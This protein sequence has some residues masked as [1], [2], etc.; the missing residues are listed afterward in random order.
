MLKHEDN[1]QSPSPSAAKVRVTPEELAAAVTALQIRKEGSP[2]TIAIGDA[3]DELGLD[4]SP[5]EVLAELERLHKRTREQTQTALRK[6][7]ATVLASFL[8]LCLSG[9]GLY[10][11]T[12]GEALDSSRIAPGTAPF[13]LEPDILALNTASAT[14][15]VT[16]LTEAPFGR[17]LYCSP[18]AIERAAVSREYQT[19]PQRPLNQSLP[20]MTWPVVKYGKD[21]YVRGWI[22]M[23]LSKEA[24]KI[25]DIEV[26]NKPYLPQLGSHPQQVTFRLEGY[27]GSSYQRLNP[28]GTGEFI[29]HNPHTTAHTYE[30]WQQ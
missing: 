5:E 8:L 1:P 14:P 16:T 9:F 7:K 26:F 25:S 24:A 6:R 18:D 17:T 13:N 27:A 19:E 20:E 23:P 30:K 29:F 2:G 4:V 10:S 28:D 15:I 22:S 12:G 21:L 3:V 11:A